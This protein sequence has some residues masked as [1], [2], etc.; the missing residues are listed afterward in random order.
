MTTAVTVETT[1]IREAQ[2]RKR[3]PSLPSLPTSVVVSELSPAVEKMTEEEAE[4]EFA[5]CLRMLD[6]DAE[7]LERIIKETP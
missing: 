4:A 1:V 5:R 3:L 7:R 6:Q 2:E